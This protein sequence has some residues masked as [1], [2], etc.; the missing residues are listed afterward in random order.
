[1]II[2]RP[3]YI[4]FFSLSRSAAI[5]YFVSFCVLN[6]LLSSFAV[7]SGFSRALHSQADNTQFWDARI[8]NLQII[9]SYQTR[10]MQFNEEEL[11][12]FGKLFNEHSLIDDLN[13]YSAQNNAERAATF[14]ADQLTNYPN[15]ST[16]INQILESVHPTETESYLALAMDD[17]TL[18]AL[19]TG[20]IYYEAG[21]FH[22]TAALNVA[23]KELGELR[24]A[25]PES[26]KIVF[27]V[28]GKTGR[29]SNFLY[30]TTEAN[31]IW[32]QESY[33]KVVNKD[34]IGSEDLHFIHLREI[35]ADEARAEGR[36]VSSLDGSVRTLK[37]PDCSR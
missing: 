11:S 26:K 5:F 35:T 30:Q 8:R 33:F 9:E 29:L 12:F 19:R 24:E 32:Q 1:M 28:E 22:S 16:S 37:T 2:H 31:M 6:L 4:T 18:N 10:N 14:E 27:K 13:L 20:S 15:L 34:Y 3:Q 25:F 17:P 7:A 21:F 36:V 23:Y